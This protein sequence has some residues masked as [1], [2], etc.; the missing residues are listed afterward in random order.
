M[1]TREIIQSLPRSLFEVKCLECGHFSVQRGV[2]L[3][4][5]KIRECQQC[6]ISNRDPN[7]NTAFLRTRGN[8]KTRN[9]EFSISKSYYESVSKNNCYY[10]NQKPM[11]DSKDSVSRC[12]S[13]NGLDR[14]DPRYGYIENNVV[15]CCKYCNYAKHNL[16][17]TEFKEWLIKCYSHTILKGGGI[18]E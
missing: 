3:E 10:C 7:L 15:S 9:I 12:P 14:I 18:S 6:K 1:G 5:L 2:D 8:A 17:L 4:L 11:Q 16:S 13:Y